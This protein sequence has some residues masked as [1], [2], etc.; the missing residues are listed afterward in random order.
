MSK[1]Q[2]A[3]KEGRITQRDYDRMAVYKWCAYENNEDLDYN[4][5]YT[6]YGLQKLIPSVQYYTKAEEW[7]AAV[8]EIYEVFRGHVDEDKIREACE[9]W[10]DCDRVLVSWT[11]SWFWVPEGMAGGDFAFLESRLDDLLSYPGQLEVYD[12][13]DE[14]M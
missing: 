12:A 9:S 11:C 14:D 13:A 5:D 2:S 8:A 6:D 10:Y 4:K 3:L 1:N 7:S